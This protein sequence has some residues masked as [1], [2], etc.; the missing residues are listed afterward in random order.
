[1]PADRRL[2]WAVACRPMP[3]ADVSGD[4]EV[5]VDLGERTVIAVADGLGHGRAAQSAAAVAAAVVRRTPDEPVDL[6]MRACNEA[7]GATRGAAIT[8]VAVADGGRLDW[9][10]V[11]NVEAAILRGGRATIGSVE[12]VYHFPGV[13]GGQ[14]PTLHALTSH[15]ARGDVIVVSTDGIG[16]DYLGDPS[17]IGP[18]ESAANDVLE[19]HGRDTDD[20]LVLV[21]RVL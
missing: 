15:V 8:L 20:A 19:T 21:A 17:P 13:V 11:G 3:G 1:M 14:L 2:E 10:A 5:V 18:V 4:V 7:M 9:L 12:T 6:L 16:G